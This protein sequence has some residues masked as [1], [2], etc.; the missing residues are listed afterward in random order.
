LITLNN[1]LLKELD[2][3]F[4]AYLIFSNSST[5]LVSQ[6]KKFA[7]LLTF[8]EENIENHPDIKVVESENLYTLGVDD[9]RDIISKDNLSPL[10]G[11]YKVVIFP[12]LKSL[13]EEASNALLKTIEEP[14]QSSIFLILSA[15]VFWSHA[16][17]DSNNQ[18]LSTIKS[19]CRPIYLD[20]E[21]DLKFDYSSD[22]FI[23]FVDNQHIDSNLS[24]KKLLTLL[25]EWKND[26]KNLSKAFQIINACKDIID[27]IDENSSINT[28]FLIVKSIS[29]LTNSLIYNSEITK[30]SFRDAEAIEKA[31]LDINLGMRPQTVFAKLSV[32]M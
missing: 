13:T 16:R 20:T 21:R 9:I 25:S 31:M 29:Y 7:S 24:F 6:A 27:E 11:R 2:N 22:D 15:G 3:P 10:E 14:S 19:R 1:S 30:Q 18:I 12:P 5:E 28:N 32:E 8:D 23:K 4:H 17:D 26:I